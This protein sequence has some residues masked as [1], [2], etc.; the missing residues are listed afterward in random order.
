MNN[1][2]QILGT[3]GIVLICFSIII[4]YIIKKPLLCLFILFGSM[5]AGCACLCFMGIVLNAYRM[6][7][8]MITFT[9]IMLVYYFTPEHKKKY[10][11]IFIPV[12]IV[13]LIIGSRINSWFM[14]I[15][16]NDGIS[17]PYSPEIF[18]VISSI[19]L[20]IG[21]VSVS[22]YDDEFR[23]SFFIAGAVIAIFVGLIFFSADLGLWIPL[24]IGIGAC[25][26]AMVVVPIVSALLPR[27]Y[28]D[29]PSNL[30]PH[31]GAY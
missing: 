26:Y 4:A 19:I 24:G 6:V 8:P 25:I 30:K 5:T 27:G 15:H 17:F 23:E 13:I 31:G 20:M 28:E 22:I 1:F 16:N 9:I 18:V 12:V 10:T 3:I 7:V 14:G 11:I 21:K 29:S 2:A